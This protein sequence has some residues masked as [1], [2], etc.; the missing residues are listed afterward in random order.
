M[1]R[2]D[3]YH[4]LF[5]GGIDGY[6]PGA[7]QRLSLSVVEDQIELAV[8]GSGSASFGFTAP[9]SMIYPGY[10]VGVFIY[11]NHANTA[12]FKW[13]GN[14]ASASVGTIYPPSS[15]VQTSGNSSGVAFRGQFIADWFTTSGTTT[16]TVEFQAYVQTQ[17]PKIFLVN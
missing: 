6:E 8:N 2:G 12:T 5:W 4:D 15:P 3:T 9:T 14:T 17:I 16:I 10:Y 1:S 7:T 13:A 11:S